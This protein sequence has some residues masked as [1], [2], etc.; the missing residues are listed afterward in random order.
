VWG[1]GGRLPLLIS[2]VGGGFLAIAL[3][4]SVRRQTVSWAKE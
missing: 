2:G 1:A 3:L 4:S